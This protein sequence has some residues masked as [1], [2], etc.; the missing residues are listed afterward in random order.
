MREL[1]K[2]VYKLDVVLLGSREHLCVNDKINHDHDKALRYGCRQARRNT[3][4]SYFSNY[5]K[6]PMTIP[7][8]GLSIEELNLIG[9]VVETCPYYT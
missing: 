2:T 3:D 7:L 1:K 5:E 4:C 6:R 9:R 8:D